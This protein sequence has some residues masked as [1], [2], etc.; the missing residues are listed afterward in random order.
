MAEI[1]KLYNISLIGEK[2]L[3]IKMDAVNRS[4][5]NA[6]KNF[7][8]LKA[9]LAQG[10]LST[11]EMK[12]LK[13]AME[14]ARLETIKLNQERI[15]L[16][17]DGRALSNALK[18]ERADR[19][20]NNQSLSQSTNEYKEATKQLNILRNDAKA[21]GKEFGIE[22]EVFIQAAKKVNVL[23]K[24]IKEIDAALGQ[25]QRNVGNYPKEINIGKISTGAIDSLRNAGLGDLLGNQLDQTK[26]KVI[27]LNTEFAEMKARLDRARLDGV[28]DLNALESEIIQNR[29]ETDRL[30][31]EIQSSQ[32]H[33]AGM[34]SV[35]TGVFSRMG[36]D[37]KSMIL[38][39]VG[40]QATMST[41]SSTVTRSIEFDSVNT[42]IA[43]VSKET[44]DYAVNQKFLEDTTERLGL[45]LLDT[46]NS[47]KLFFAA[48]TQ[49]GISAESTREIFESA[50][51]AASTMK[52][53]QEAT[54]GVMLAFGQ[55]ASKGK[56]QAEELRGQI[57]ERI[58]GA[59][60]IA[61]KAMGVTTAELD[62]MMKDGK[63]MA[64]DFLPKF[65]KQLK[66]TYGAGQEP[67]K[68]LRAELNR[69]DNFIS[70]VANNKSFTNFISFSISLLFGF[71]SVVTSIP[72]GWWIGMMG[73]LTVAYWSNIVAIAA[74]T[75]ATIAKMGAQVKQIAIQAISNTL[76]LASTIIN[77]AAAVAIYAVAY[78]YQFL[79]IVLNVLTTIFPVLRT[80]MLAL[81][82][83]ILATPIGW[84]VA[85]IIA[86]TAV[87]KAFGN[88]VDNTSKKI[89]AQGEALKLTA[90]QMR[91]NA[92]IEK[93]ANEAT[94]ERIAKIQVLTQ[95]ASDLNNSDASR[96]QALEELIAID[97][98]YKTA[99][100]GNII[101]T[102]KLNEI[103]KELTASILEQAKAEAARAMLVD[104]QKQILDNDFKR[105]E[106]KTKIGKEGTFKAIGKDALNIF[107]IGEGSTSTE[108]R[109]LYD[110]NTELKEQVNYLASLVAKEKT[111]PK[112]KN[113][114]GTP[115]INPEDPKNPKDPSKLSGG[116]KDYLRDINALREA[117][118][119]ELKK[120]RLEGL[121]TEE[122]FL[123]KSLAVNIKYNDQI[124][125][126]FKGTDAATR[127]L[128]ADTASD[129]I[130]KRIE[131]NTKLFKI[132]E[133]EIKQ[134]LENQSKLS[135]DK[136][137]NVNNDPYA[138]DVDK[139][140]AE[141]VY[142][143]EM[144]KN[145]TDFNVKMDLLEKKL[146][147]E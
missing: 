91:V 59:F 142:W 13:T 8:E 36:G 2:E 35:G 144:V 17:N 65:A 92:E 134:T 16:T 118:L 120:Q 75:V 145:Q 61:A 112:D 19:I 138:S 110:K 63:L 78:S 4:F 50:S 67:V 23:D 43:S 71:V 130:D 95:I 104:K 90:A 86:V 54:N 45:K 98:R 79:N 85:G 18:Q 140:E 101:K 41:V 22:S 122:D 14:L 123:K 40:L 31:N 58:P 133:D 105:S 73:F 93:K 126:H 82:S 80:A 55:I 96:K 25:F 24:E 109:N 44:G 70:K 37:I 26:G 113:P 128:R 135:Q 106:A 111:K 84:L 62:K 121:I 107:G 127:K 108:S 68:G 42:A 81:N 136:L 83:T 115:P 49:S 11:E 64:N 141:K 7:L 72:F 103:T 28:Q 57:G 132:Q 10:N 1:K 12:N 88:E 146:N 102:G 5:D 46:S 147:I 6:K 27:Q 21:L 99:L 15:R 56:V 100:D 87:S 69:L 9:T 60:G 32:T 76:I 34:G 129:T 114:D 30:N 66:E 139:A 29:I 53:S 3:V 89:R 38:G 47:F 33:L 131:T 51:E 137:N 39:Y 94:S 143:E 52:L 48:S 20:A 119:S 77:Y 97:G 124:L 125:A 74:S 116:Q 117:N